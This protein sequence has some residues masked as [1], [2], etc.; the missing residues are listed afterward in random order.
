MIK[1]KESMYVNKYGPEWKVRWR[2]DDP[3][4]P[5]A[6]HD[7]ARMGLKC[8]FI[9]KRDIIEQIKTCN[10]LLKDDLIAVDIETCKMFP[11]EAE[12]YH[13]PSKKAGFEY[14]QEK[15]VD[16]FNHTMS[17]FR[18]TM[19]NLKI[20]EKKGS[21]TANHPRTDGRVHET[22]WKSPMKSSAARYM[23]R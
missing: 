6:R 23:P 21:I 20:L 2:F 19:E 10:T 5:T 13:Y 4:V 8:M 14:E 18:Y 3:A 1:A 12:A 15:P 9:C 16:D 22:V 7:F 11:L 17:N